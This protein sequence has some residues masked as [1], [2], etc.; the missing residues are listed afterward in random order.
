M[1]AAF[2][3]TNKKNVH[4][5]DTMQSASATNKLK[6]ARLKSGDN[7]IN[8]RT[9]N[10]QGTDTKKA[11]ASNWFNLMKGKKE[12]GVMDVAFLQEPTQLHT[13]FRNTKDSIPEH[14][15]TESARDSGLSHTG[16]P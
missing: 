10:V 4:K 7:L 1:E 14:G 2:A 12:T 15:D 11:S 6:G 13:R 8:I 16:Q 3:A 9:Q 5:Q